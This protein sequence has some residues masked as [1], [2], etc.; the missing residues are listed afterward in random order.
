MIEYI[1]EYGRRQIQSRI[2][3]LKNGEDLRDDLLTIILRA[4]SGE[5]IDMEAMID[6]FVLF[7]FAGIYLEITF[8][9]LNI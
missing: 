9:A 2:D 5:E 1:R 3:N 8:L 7:F 6:N 4:S